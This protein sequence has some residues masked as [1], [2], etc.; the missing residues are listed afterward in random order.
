VVSDQLEFDPEVIYG[1]NWYKS[2]LTQ[3]AA[4][5]LAAWFVSDLDVPS[6][7]LVDLFYQVILDAHLAD[8][9]ELRLQPIDVI[10]FI[11]ECRF[12]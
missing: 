11:L 7:E 4:G 1:R 2:G 9:V 12:E 10:F 3:E 8:L 5:A 6:G